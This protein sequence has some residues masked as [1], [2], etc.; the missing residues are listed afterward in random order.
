MDDGLTQKKCI[1]CE[2]G[3]L[4]LTRIEADALLAQVP[5][6]TLN[7]DAKRLSRALPFADFKSALAFADRVGELA[8]KEGHHP[9][10][11]VAWGSLGIE[12]WT[13]AVGGLSEND[14]IMAAKISSMIP[15]RQ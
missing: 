1:P 3:G 14:F 10:L 4:A 7:Q 8:E 11:T 12:L 9:V 5:G 6:W 15:D 2:V 13:H